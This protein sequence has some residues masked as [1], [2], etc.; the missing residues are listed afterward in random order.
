MSVT[1]GMSRAVGG[2]W[3]LDVGGAVCGTSPVR[4]IGGCSNVEIAFCPVSSTA[5]AQLPDDVSNDPPM[6]WMELAVEPRRWCDG[7]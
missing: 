6:E 1:G 4:T 2:L 3:V 5:S 7:R